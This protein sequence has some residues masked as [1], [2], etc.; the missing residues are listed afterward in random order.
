MVEVENKYRTADWEP[1]QSLLL[2]WGA[3]PAARRE[4]TDHYFNAPD[5]DFAQTDEAFRLRRIGPKNILTY[6]GPK[7]DTFTKTRTELELDLADGPSAATDAVKLVACL[8]Y[9]PVAVVTKTREVWKFER[10]G[11]HFEAC[12]DDVGAIGKFVELETQAEP[13]NVDAAKSALLAVAA[14]LGLKDVERNSYLQLLL[15]RPKKSG[16]MA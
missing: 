15:G 9:R 2:A 14:E 5:R 8:G 6:K 11:F 10:G 16:G 7:Q 12:F 4:D 3:I 1:L 13:A